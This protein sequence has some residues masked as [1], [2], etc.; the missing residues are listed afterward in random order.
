MFLLKFT[1]SKKTSVRFGVINNIVR[2]KN[3]LNETTRASIQL[4]PLENSPKILYQLTQSNTPYH[5]LIL[6]LKREHSIVRC[7]NILKT[8]VYTKRPCVNQFSTYLNQISSHILSYGEKALGSNEIRKA[9]VNKFK[10]SQHF[11][12]LSKKK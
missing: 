9:S 11:V 7:F 2:E 5:S 10:W 8:M 4:W 6:P 12:S 1:K 3:K